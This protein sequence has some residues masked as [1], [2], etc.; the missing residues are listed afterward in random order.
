M[1][2]VVWEY[3]VEPAQ[4]PAFEAAYGEGGAWVALFATDPAW[5]GTRLLKDAA[6][7]GVYVTI[8]CWRSAK[9]YARFRA[10]QA[11]AYAGIDDRCAALTRRET[12]L[13]AG[14]AG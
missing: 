7:S 12:R 5:L 9:D 10:M 1:H 6:T 2:V 13:F 3:E 14:D 8:D 11:R 4:V